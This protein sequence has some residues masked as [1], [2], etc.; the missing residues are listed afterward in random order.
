M[1]VKRPRGWITN[2]LFSSSSLW[3]A[4]KYPISAQSHLK[5]VG[6]YLILYVVFKMAVFTKNDLRLNELFEFDMTDI[7]EFLPFCV[8]AGIAVDSVPFDDGSIWLCSCLC[9]LFC[10]GTSPVWLSSPLVG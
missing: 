8:V 10:G 3:K 5:P 7:T 9:S 4:P 1:I 2:W 6:P